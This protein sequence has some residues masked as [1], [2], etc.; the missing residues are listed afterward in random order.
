MRPRLPFLSLLCQQSSLWTSK[1]CANDWRHSFSYAGP[2]AWNTP[3]TVYHQFFQAS[4]QSCSFCSCL[5]TLVILSYVWFLFVTCWYRLGNFCKNCPQF[6]K[7][8]IKK[9]KGFLNETPCNSQLVCSHDS[10]QQVTTMSAISK[11][12]AMWLINSLVAFAH[13]SVLPF[14]WGC[15]F[16]KCSVYEL[17]VYSDNDHLMNDGRLVGPQFSADCRILQTALLNLA[18]FSVETVVPNHDNMA[19]IPNIKWQQ[20]HAHKQ[21]NKIRRSNVTTALYK[22]YAETQTIKICYTITCQLTD[23]THNEYKNTIKTMHSM[24]RQLYIDADS[25]TGLWNQLQNVGRCLW[26]KPWPPASQVSLSRSSRSHS[27]H[28]IE[29]PSDWSA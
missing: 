9:P 19:E 6:G 14:L 8:I 2:L 22:L 18:K 25:I 21:H 1:D 4:S 5:R 27:A 17:Y 15:F 13:C 23:D 20:K 28:N 10:D 7:D 29:M 24:P 3:Q 26:H 11:W 16:V 12:S